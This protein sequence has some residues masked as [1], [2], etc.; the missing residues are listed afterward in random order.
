MKPPLDTEASV[1]NTTVMVLPEECTWVPAG[2]VPQNRCR[3]GASTANP[4][5]TCKTQRLRWRHGATGSAARQRRAQDQLFH[6]SYAVNVGITVICSECELTQRG[7]YR[8]FRCSH[9]LECS[10]VITN[11]HNKVSITEY[12]MLLID[13]SI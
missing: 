6:W 8:T 13:N 12:P 5:R 7:L 9:E 3:R 2:T 10:T 1:R 11:S 4:F